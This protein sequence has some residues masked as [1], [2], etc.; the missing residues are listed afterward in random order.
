MQTFQI[1]TKKKLKQKGKRKW[2]RS[3]LCGRQRNSVFAEIFSSKLIIEHSGSN[4]LLTFGRIDLELSIRSEMRDGVSFRLKKKIFFSH[5]DDW[6]EGLENVGRFCFVLFCFV[7]IWIWIFVFSSSRDSGLMSC[8]R[9]LVFGGKK[10]LL[11]QQVFSIW[12]KSNILFLTFWTFEKI[13]ILFEI[14][15]FFLLHS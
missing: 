6:L 11:F 2:S 7:F 10:N 4:I 9:F 15:I 13:N 8:K 3:G 5:D 1:S 14:S 12:K